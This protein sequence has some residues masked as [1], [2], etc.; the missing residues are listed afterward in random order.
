MARKLETVEIQEKLNSL[1]N[2]DLEDRKISKTFKFK[3]YMDS[4]NFINELAVVAEEKSSTVLRTNDL[5]PT[6]SSRF[7]I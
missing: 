5:N 1:N 6:I 4:I 7:S 2:W 3:S